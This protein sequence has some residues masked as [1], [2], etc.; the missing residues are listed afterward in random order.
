MDRL[1]QWKVKPAPRLQIVAR[2]FA[3]RAKEWATGDQY[4]TFAELDA[5]VKIKL[6]ELTTVMKPIP[7]GT[8]IFIDFKR[9]ITITTGR[10]EI[11]LLK[12]SAS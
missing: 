5:R 3:V 12:F 7:T 4:G 10:E 8:V 1:I 6:P 11:F 2:G 9:P